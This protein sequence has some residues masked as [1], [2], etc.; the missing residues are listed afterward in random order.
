MRRAAI[1]LSAALLLA[2]ACT[3]QPSVLPATVAAATP[4]VTPPAVTADTPFKPY[5][6]ELPPA[7]PET[8]KHITL[9]V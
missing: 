7:G 3:N 6:A 1:L 9:E 2:T 5:P 8:T 4:V